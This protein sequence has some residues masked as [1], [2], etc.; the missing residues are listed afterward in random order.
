MATRH[1]RAK[2]LIMKR[3]FLIVLAV[4]LC[5]FNLFADKVNDNGNHVFEYVISEL[6]EKGFYD[7][8]NIQ[9]NSSYELKNIQLKIFINGKEHQ[10]LPISKLKSGNDDNFDGL[11]DDE[12]HDEL[13]HY[14]GNDGKLNKKNNNKIRFELN[15][16]LNNDKVIVTDLYIRDKELYFYVEDNSEHVVTE[17]VLE[18]QVRVIEIDGKKYM[19]VDDKVIE[20]K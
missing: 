10:L 19:L 4:L 5:S 3:K 13:R 17:Q 7:E 18:E 20:I 6:V 12:M 1:W 16:G 8:I 2:G 14:F 11:E 15:F 9:N